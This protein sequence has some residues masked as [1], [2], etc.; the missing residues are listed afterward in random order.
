MQA[1]IIDLLSQISI[2]EMTG[3]QNES[4]VTIDFSRFQWI[5]CVTTMNSTILLKR[6]TVTWKNANAVSD[7]CRIKQQRQRRRPCVNRTRNLLSSNSM[8]NQ[9]VY[10][11]V[12]RISVSRPSLRLMSEK[13][14]HCSDMN[15]SVSESAAKPTTIPQQNT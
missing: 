4:F 7:L 12:Y 5:C 2:D 8:M 3:E 11:L 14:I 6:L 13:R 9:Q 1:R 15:P 10:P